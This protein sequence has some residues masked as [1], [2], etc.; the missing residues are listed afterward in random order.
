[1]KKLWIL[2]TLVL[3]LGVTLACGGGRATPAPS[4][5]QATI[6]QWAIRTQAS[7]E[8]GVDDWSAKQATGAPD[9]AECGD[10]VTAWASSGNDTVEWLE[11][12]FEQPVYA[13][14][15]HIVQSYTPDQVVKVE[16]IAVNGNYTTVY[17]QQPQEVLT[18]CPYTLSVRTSP[19]DFPVQGARLTIDQSQLGLGWNE[20]DAVQ[21]VGI[22]VGQ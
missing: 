11:V 12:Y 5:T 18:P 10:Y 20:I 9:T 21:L 2:I 7:S 8:Y 22:P 19:T 4:G 16:F 1:M 3:I 15:L 14:E 13:T 6:A 17:T